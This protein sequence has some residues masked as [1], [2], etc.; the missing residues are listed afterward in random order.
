MIKEIIRPNHCIRVCDECADEKKV[1]Y[2][3]VKNKTTHL[4]SSCSNKQAFELK[5]DGYK[6]WNIG[7]TYQKCSGNSYINQH[8]YK[9]YYIGDKSYKGGYVSEHRIVVELSLGRR[10]KKGEVVHHIDGN[11]QNNNASNLLLTDKSNHKQVHH[12]LEKLA[13][14]LVQKGLIKFENNNYF[15]EPNMWEHIS[16]SLE[17]LENPIIKNEDN[18]QQSPLGNTKEECSTTIQKWSTLK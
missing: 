9:L 14:N 12:S 6:P 11:K 18:Q 10:L 17:L 15:I 16:K 13:F 3:G 7:K 4:C 1:S 8:G 2:W 5:K